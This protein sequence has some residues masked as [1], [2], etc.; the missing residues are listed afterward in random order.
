MSELKD[1]AVL[2]D[3][4][5]FYKAINRLLD[6]TGA[7]SEAVT[8]IQPF[9]MIF[10]KTGL[11]KGKILV[12]RSDSP[13]K[14]R[15]EYD[16]SKNKVDIYVPAERLV[17]PAS[18][19]Y[20]FF[21]S[22]LEE[23]D[24]SEFGSDIDTRNVTDMSYMFSDCIYLTTL[25]LSHFDT[26]KVTDM[27]GM[28]YW[29]SALTTLDVSHFDTSNVTSMYGMFNCCSLLTTLKLSNFVTTKVTYM[30]W[31]FNWCSALTTLDISSFDTSLVE[32]MNTMFA[33]CSKLST[34]KLGR[35]FTIARGC[36]T[37]DMLL[38]TPTDSDTPTCTVY[39][40][41]ATQTRL[42]SAETGIVI[43]KFRWDNY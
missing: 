33:N 24:W 42:S 4:E 38:D 37:E 19:K 18:C 29:C 5:D 7:P 35:K 21:L 12:S 26:S 11:P 20:M 8:N 6:P 40:T 28:F 23:I 34:L 25:D 17:F 41:S 15:A 9:K 22:M 36:N 27:S 31:M 32:D 2:A 3:G 14:V 16:D 1:Y 30:D 39:C 10:H 43:S 13:V